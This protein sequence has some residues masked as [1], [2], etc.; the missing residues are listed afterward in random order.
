RKRSLF[1]VAS[2]DH[3][4]RDHQDGPDI[5]RDFAEGSL[6]IREAFCYGDSNAQS[7]VGKMLHLDFFHRVHGVGTMHSSVVRVEK[8]K[9]GSAQ[10][11]DREDPRTPG[12]SEPASCAEDFDDAEAEEN[13]GKSLVLKNFH[14]SRKSHPPAF[15][16]K[17]PKFRVAENKY[18]NSGEKK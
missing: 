8:K 4:Q 6:G 3:A 12:R 7:G 2:Q 17:G 1:R 9:D 10:R 13:H 18:K 11:E 5:A 16:A 15:A 14:I